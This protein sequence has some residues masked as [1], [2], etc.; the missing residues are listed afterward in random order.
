MAFPYLVRTSARAKTVRIEVTP[1]RVVVIVP[2][3]YDP[4]LIPHVVARKQTWIEKSQAKLLARSPAKPAL[5]P[6]KLELQA[7]A[8]TWTIDYLKHNRTESVKLE[9]N[10][11]QHRLTLTSGYA[12]EQLPQDLWH[13]ALANWL[14]C[15]GQQHLIPWLQTVSQELDLPYGQSSIRGQKTLWASCSSTRNISLNYKLLFVA[16]QLVK[17]VFVHELCHTR[18]MNH[19][20][21]FWQLVAAKMPDYRQWDR[22]LIQ[23]WRQLPPGI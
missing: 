16:P 17:Y 5:L 6:Q 9:V 4:N 15:Q 23:A 11:A 20:P 7:I 12:L 19:S 3:N 10:P 18:H 2:Q 21:K 14:R 8:Q 1:E 22:A 13:Q